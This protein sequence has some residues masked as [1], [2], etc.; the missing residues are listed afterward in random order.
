MFRGEGLFIAQAAGFIELV[1]KE[2]TR[3]DEKM[4]TAHRRIENLQFQDLCWLRIV[5]RTALGDLGSER[6][7][8]EEPDEGM[9]G[10]VRTAR[11][12][13]QPDA[14]IEPVGG[15]FLDPF[16]LGFLAAG[17]LLFVFSLLLVCLLGFNLR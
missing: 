1:A 16:H 12:A 13:A 7:L 11:L 5:V 6:F 3:L 4:P 10:V 2:A 17:R 9:R 14:Q 8:H 15:N